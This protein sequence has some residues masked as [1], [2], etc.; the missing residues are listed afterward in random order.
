[1][2]ESEIVLLTEMIKLRIKNSLLY[3]YTVLV[4]FSLWIICLFHSSTYF[5]TKITN[6]KLF[7][8][9]VMHPPKCILYVSISRPDTRWEEAL[10]IHLLAATRPN[11]G[12]EG[13]HYSIYCNKYTLK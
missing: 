10:V 6:S 5:V 8:I 4:S 11:R 1:M 3:C 13:T 2:N 9:R 7:R 12:R